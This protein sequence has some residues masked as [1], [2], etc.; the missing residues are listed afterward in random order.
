MREV[1]R[2]IA[3][4]ADLALS[5]AEHWEAVEEAAE[6]WRALGIVSTPTETFITYLGGIEGATGVDRG[7]ALHRFYCPEEYDGD[8]LAEKARSRLGIGSY[9]TS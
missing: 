2:R 3:L 4:P 8:D 5:A 1:W 9:G 7:E 6:R